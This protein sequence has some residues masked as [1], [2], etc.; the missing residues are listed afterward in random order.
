MNEE[1]KQGTILVAGEDADGAVMSFEVE[2]LD[3]D[4]DLGLVGELTRGRGYLFIDPLPERG[5]WKVLAYED[6]EKED[7][8][9]FFEATFTNL[10]LFGGSRL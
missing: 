8:E 7:A 5:L 9:P 3:L 6:A 10:R 4:E 2:R 1:P